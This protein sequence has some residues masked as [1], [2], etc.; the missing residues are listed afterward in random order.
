MNKLEVLKSKYDALDKEAGEYNR[1][2]FD[3]VYAIIDELL[4]NHDDVGD[5]GNLA[6]PLVT[7]EVIDEALSKAG[8]ADDETFVA[9]FKK[10]R[11]IE[12][13]AREIQLEALSLPEHPANLLIKEIKERENKGIGWRFCAPS[14]I[15]PEPMA[16]IMNDIF[17][18]E[19]IEGK[20]LFANMTNIPKENE[21]EDELLMANAFGVQG[22]LYAY[23]NNLEKYSIIGNPGFL[24][25]DFRKLLFVALNRAA[26][27][28]RDHSDAPAQI[29]NH[30]GYILQ[31]FDRVPIWGLFFQILILQGLC[32]WIGALDIDEGDSG[33]GEATSVYNWL[34]EALVHKEVQFCNTPYGYKNEEHLKPLTDYL[35]ATEIGQ[36]VQRILFGN[37][38]EEPDGK[39]ISESNSVTNSS[40]L[41]VGKSYEEMRRVLTAL[42]RQGFISADTTIETFYYRMTGAGKPVQGRIC[43][44]K[45]AKNKAISLTS[46]IDFL[47][48]IGVK[49]ESALSQ[50]D[51]VF[52][53]ED[54]SNIKLPDDTKT[55]ARKKNRNNQD[56]SA[57]HQAIKTI[58]DE[59]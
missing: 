55:T 49:L 19:A 44:I 33:Y 8:Y 58:I 26:T 42:Q 32:E 40:H 12:Q 43:W 1:P 41:S 11:E 3:Q 13:K 14:I 31:F 30:I 34:C 37:P 36:C 20:G 54:S 56:L 51:D 50:V 5:N 27:F 52:C 38:V 18:S 6:Y 57:Y 7:G 39:P 2:E 24:N 4:Q 17:A 48:T 22:S 25:D 9:D 28:I 15:V 46:L 29:K 53:R 45:K 23:R 35:Y 10:Y 21:S 59:E 47:V 16:S